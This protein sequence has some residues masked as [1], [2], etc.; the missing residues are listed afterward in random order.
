MKSIRIFALT[1]LFTFGQTLWA[2]DQRP[3]AEEMHRQLSQKNQHGE[4]GPKKRPPKEAIEACSSKASNDT[5]QFNG[6]NN[7]AV[8]GTCFS[9]SA[10]KPLACKPSEMK[11][12]KES[13][14]PEGE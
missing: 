7:E 3:P 13:Q 1:A 14:A 6:K 10:D 5:C 8:S 2:Q 12:K 11:E 4:S 9:P